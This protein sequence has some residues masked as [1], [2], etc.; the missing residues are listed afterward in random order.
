MRLIMR[1]QIKDYTN[2]ITLERPKYEAN[3]FSSFQLNDL[4]M[5][6]VID[7]TLDD[8]QTLETGVSSEASVLVLDPTKDGIAQISGYLAKRQDIRSLHIVSHGAPGRLFIGSST[9]D[10]SSLEEY[11]E[12]LQ[13]WSNSIQEI[14]LYGCQVAQGSV[15]SNFVTQLSRLTGATIA[16]SEDLTGNSEL[17]GNWNLEWTTG[18]IESPLAFK[19]SAMNAY[20][21]VLATFIATNTAELIQAIED[22]NANDEA[23]VIE[24]V[25]GTT[26]NLTES[27]AGNDAIDGDLEGFDYGATGLPF[28][29]SDITINGNGATIAR[30]SAS[31]DF[32]LFTVVGSEAPLFAPPFNVFPEV[33]G[34]NLTL[35]DVTLTGGRTEQDIGDT[36][37]G[38]L[39]DGGAILNVN[40]VVNINS[41]TITGNESGDD[42]GAISNIFGGT[43]NIENSEITDNEA[44]LNPDANGANGGAIDND[45]GG[46][47]QTET[48]IS[49][50]EITDNT[51]SGDGGGVSNQNEGVVTIA[52][53]SEVANNQAPVGTGEDV[54]NEVDPTDTNIINLAPDSDV[55]VA[56]GPINNIA[57]AVQFTENSFTVSEDGNVIGDAIVLERVGD[58]SGQTTV[59]I[60]FSDGTATGGVDFENT[61]I[62]VTFDPGEDTLTFDALPII[63]DADEEGTEDF[64]VNLANISPDAAIGTPSS[65]TIDILDNDGAGSLT[66]TPDN[67]F[68]VGGGGGDLKVTLTGVEADFVNEIGIYVVED[69]QTVTDILSD[70][71]VIFSSLS[72][73]SSDILTEQ[74]FSI[75][76]RILSGFATGQE[77]GFYLVANSSSDAVL[78]GDA[79]E[80]NVFIGAPATINVSEDSASVFSIGFEDFGGSA[81]FDDLEVTFEFATESVIGTDLQ[82]EVE[83]IDLTDFGGQLVQ[84]T[85]NSTSQ[86]DFGNIGGLYVIEDASGTVID[87]LTGSSLTPGDAGYAEAAV[88][89]SVV[90]FGINNPESV[91][92]AGGFIYA[93]YLLADGEISGFLSAFESANPDGLDH[94]VLLGDNFFSF[95]DE[96]GLGD[97]DFNDFTFE[98]D[99][100]IV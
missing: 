31:E 59:D 17:G 57:T 64:T 85:I 80:S 49:G 41:S 45:G 78:S 52:G 27:F 69:G 44:G 81:D 13:S 47:V 24:L 76:M 29:T 72:S 22:A 42:G 93:P 28:I 84:A 35:N 1:N 65:A 26:Y 96:S 23:D 54:F 95:E 18:K 3:Y 2:T 15:G 51:S 61:T 56:D 46:L 82:G 9:L 60:V 71:Q 67:T 89:Q 33:D 5:L 58:I 100:N 48:N 21:G 79:P 99:L 16:A 34:G 30:L 7:T 32:R 4:R 86:A 37:E 66:L 6:V 40:G 98:V 38:V 36:V 43:L 92:L 73:G 90:E 50:T 91:N 11:S 83:V 88:S 19:P 70:G 77:V 10:I 25:A 8:Y 74:G 39:D 68:I 12:Q 53:G 75:P 62:S 14:L 87:P 63:D 20:R 97:Q 55:E 94:V